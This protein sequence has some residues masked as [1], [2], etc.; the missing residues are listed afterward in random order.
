MSKLNGLFAVTLVA[1][2]ALTGCET[3]PQSP[4]LSGRVTRFHAIDAA[5]KTYLLVPNE[6][7]GSLEWRTYA[8]LVRQNLSAY[9]WT[10][11][12]YESAD[13]AVF[14]QYEIGQG[15]QI[16]F[17]RPVYGLVPSGNSTTTG[18]INSF[19]NTT[20]VNATTTQEQVLG[21]VG[22]ST[23]GH[24][25]YDRAVRVS[26]Y[27]MSA[28]RQSERLE[29]VYEG[30][31]RSTGTTGD[32]PTVMPALVD[33]LFREFP[34]RSGSTNDV[35]MAIKPATPPGNYRPANY[36]GSPWQI[37][38]QKKMGIVSDTYTTKINGK[39]ISET[40][41]WDITHRSEAS[42]G[43]HEGRTVSTDCSEQGEKVV[44]TVMVDGVRAWAGS[45]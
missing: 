34:G 13:V 12:P 33:G 40:K 36:T 43:E 9:G 44:C 5:P 3:V 26:M 18:T 25:E 14:L 6:G 15:R 29:P 8:A 20:T 2:F 45:Y 1:A 23:G 31:I 32:L 4:S 28:V 19:G 42:Q 24:T 7:T 11:A 39:A 38:V 30:E 41:V 17:S 21:V 16:T 10:E 27:S 35:S 22:T 37:S